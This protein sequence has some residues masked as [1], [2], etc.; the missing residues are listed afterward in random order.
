MTHNQSDQRATSHLTIAMV[1]IV[2]L[3]INVSLIH[4]IDHSG[5]K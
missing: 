1:F 3:L 4:A 5:E 2:A